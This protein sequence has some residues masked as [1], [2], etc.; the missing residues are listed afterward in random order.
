MYLD[1]D[2]ARAGLI[3]MRGATDM[4]DGIIQDAATLEPNFRSDLGLVECLLLHMWQTVQA[5]WIVD[6]LKVLDPSNTFS[7]GMASQKSGGELWRI[8]QKGKLRAL[9]WS[10]PIAWKKEDCQQII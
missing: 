3:K 2:A 8:S 5:V 7:R 4:C 9:R 6:L 1:N 10:H